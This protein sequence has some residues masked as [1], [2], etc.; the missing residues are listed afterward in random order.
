MM[1]MVVESNDP[2]SYGRVKVIIPGKWDTSTMSIECLPWVYPLTMWGYQSFS[3][4]EVNSRVWVIENTEAQE[5]YWYIPFFYLNTPTHGKA[6]KPNSDVVI[7]RTM[8]AGNAMLYCNNTEGMSM[9]VGKGAVT[10]RPDST[11]MNKS[12]DAKVIVG[13]GMVQLGTNSG[14]QPAPKGKELLNLLQKLS[15]DLKDVQQSAQSNPYTEHLVPSLS[16]TISD[17]N[18]G[19][20]NL[21]SKTVSYN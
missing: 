3:K 16:K 15:Q 5:E 4:M 7:S 1:G 9:M 14:Y 13:G 11:V 17:L 6:Q 10:V 8:S 2:T 18:D 21:L 12:G 19:L 20:K